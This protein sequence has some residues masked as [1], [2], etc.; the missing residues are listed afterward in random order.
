M[1][2]YRIKQVDFDAKYSHSEIRLINNNPKTEL[3]IHPN[4]VLAGETVTIEFG[5]LF[6]GEIQLTVNDETGKLVYGKT[7]N[8]DESNISFVVPSSLLPGAY[9]VR[10]ISN[11]NLENF[12]LIVL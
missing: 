8:T 10:I 4:P 12:L 5:E 6:E 2:Y 7:Y 3:S 1:S 11:N 9:N